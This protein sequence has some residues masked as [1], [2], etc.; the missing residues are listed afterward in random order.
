MSTEIKIKRGSGVTPALA[1]GELGYNKDTKI[2]TIG[3]STDGNIDIGRPIK[4][5]T[6]AKYN[7]ESANNNIDDDT[8]YIIE[9][10]DAVITES[11]LKD[12]AFNGSIYNG[13]YNNAPL[14]TLWSQPGKTDS[15]CSN[16]PT[17]AT[18][19]YLTTI[20]AN[21]TTLQLFQQYSS[22]AT[23]MRSDAAKKGTFPAW[24]RIDGVGAPAYE[25]GTW[26]PTDVNSCGLT[27]SSSTMNYTKIGRFVHALLK[28]KAA[29]S[30]TSKA[31]VIGG[32]PFEPNCTY[33][34][35][36]GGWTS[37]DGNGKATKTGFCV[38][39][40]AQGSYRVRLVTT[41]FADVKDSDIGA[42]RDVTISLYYQVR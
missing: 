24:I 11:I 19:G 17:G 15:G 39:D 16:Y 6:Q 41:A 3:T 28:F 2:L 4:T 7:T 18:Y 25:E 35:S 30:V 37:A 23:W 32:L 14:G 10:D 5:M 31:V 13:D 20:K 26:T 1:D 12:K 8:I 22:G 38:T 42:S 27:F 33:P 9:S 34:S 36:L 21:T 40:A 29:S